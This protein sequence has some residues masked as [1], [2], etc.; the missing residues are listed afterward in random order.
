MVLPEITVITV[1]VITV[2]MHLVG[3]VIAL[4]S[5]SEAQTKTELSQKLIISLEIWEI[6]YFQLFSFDCGL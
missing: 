3:K 6:K 1:T 5:D 2:V 4:N